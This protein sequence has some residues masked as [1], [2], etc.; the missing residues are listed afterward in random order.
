VVRKDQGAEAMEAL[1]AEVEEVDRQRVDHQEGTDMF[2]L[3]QRDHHQ[4]QVHQEVHQ[5]DHQGDHQADHQGDHQEVHQ[6]YH[7]GNHQE[8]HQEAHQVRVEMEVPKSESLT[9]FDS[10]H[11]PMWVNIGSGRGPFGH[12]CALPLEEGT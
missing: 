12:K 5:A 1:E 2:P 9:T 6:A 8:G 3:P 11:C 10:Q 7:Q 4:K